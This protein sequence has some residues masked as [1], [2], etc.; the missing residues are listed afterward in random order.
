VLV[1]L[2]GHGREDVGSD[3]DMSRTVGWFTSLFPVLLDPGAIDL[4]DALSGGHSLG[5]ALKQI[6]EQLR[7]LPDNGV[8]YG[9]LRHLN[10]KT[11]PVLANLATPQIGFNYLGR[12]I[13]PQGRDWAVAPEMATLGGSI[14]AEMP[15][16]H[17]IDLNVL[18]NDRPEGPELTA[19][20]SWGGKLFS[21]N[22]IRDLAETWFRALRALVSHAER[23]DAGG[24]TPSDLP[25][26]SLTQAE[27]DQMEELYGN[28]GW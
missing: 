10:G 12:F 9:L 24:L 8:G 4:V 5:R 27:I 3:L 28:F 14:E 19:H 16:A 13:A 21:E 20:W 15:L 22:D 25:L 23:P 26:L 6:K 18:V 11:A 1:D 17:S 7:R 2:E